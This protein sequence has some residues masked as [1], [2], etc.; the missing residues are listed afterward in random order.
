MNVTKL[1]NKANWHMA[2]RRRIY[3]MQKTYLYHLEIP[4]KSVLCIVLAEKKLEKKKIFRR[5]VFK[6]NKNEM[7]Q[8]F[9]LTEYLTNKLRK[10]LLFAL[11]QKYPSPF[12]SSPF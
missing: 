9:N 10:K 1:C 8:L 6:T 5:K 3:D 12:H 7:K 2:Q 4:T 11:F